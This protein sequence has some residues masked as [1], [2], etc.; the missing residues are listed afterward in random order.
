MIYFS[1]DL[2]LDHFNVIKLCKRP[3]S[4]LD[5]MQSSLVTNWN[6]KVTNNDSVYLLGDICFKYVTLSILDKLNGKEMFLIKGNH[7]HKRINEY[8]RFI[9]SKDLFNLKIE[10]KYYIL[11]HYPLEVW[12]RSHYGSIHLHG[13]CH[14]TLKNIKSNRLDVGIDTNNYFPY[15]IDQIHAELS[16]Q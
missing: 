14:G 16:Q 5:E 1:S 10:D 9:W 11:C 2:H 4:S 8:S 6:T 15:S 12:N 13:H 7:D 3:Y